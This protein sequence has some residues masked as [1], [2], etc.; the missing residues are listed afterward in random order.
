MKELQTKKKSKNFFFFEQDEPYRQKEHIGRYHYR[1][2]DRVKYSPVVTTNPTNPDTDVGSRA[3]GK[4]KNR[5]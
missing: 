2:L 4:G 5:C 3:K 1:R